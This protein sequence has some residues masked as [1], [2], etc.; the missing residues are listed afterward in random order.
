MLHGESPNTRADSAIGQSEAGGVSTVTM[1]PALV[2]P[3][4]KA[5]QS[6][7]MAWTAPA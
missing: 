7:T 5:V 6:C 3:K 4:K 2:D 1:L